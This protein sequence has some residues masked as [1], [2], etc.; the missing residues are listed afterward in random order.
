MKWVKR[1]IVFLVV[2]FALFYLI[3]QPAGR[4][5]RRSCRIRSSCQGVPIDHCLSSSR[6]RLAMGVVSWLDPHVDR[7]ILSTAG[8]EKVVEVKKHWAA[9][10]WPGYDSPSEL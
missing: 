7:F 10:A 5:G 1:I 4:R 9:S 2:G 3:S 8:E 6:L